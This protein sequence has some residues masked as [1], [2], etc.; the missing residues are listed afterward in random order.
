MKG[1]SHPAAKSV[2]TIRSELNLSAPSVQT[3]KFLRAILGPESRDGQNSAGKPIRQSSE[4]KKPTKSRYALKKA[5]KPRCNEDPSFPVHESPVHQ[6][7][8]LSPVDCQ[9]LATETFNATLKQ[10]S[11]A[12]KAQKTLAKPIFGSTTLPRLPLTEGVLQE[13]SPN[14]KRKVPYA[15]SKENTPCLKEPDWDVVAEC[16]FAALRF[17]Q[18]SVEA[19]T[20]DNDNNSKD[21]GIED[22]GLMLLDRSITLNLTAQ[23]YRQ[24]SDIHHRYW[25]MKIVQNYSPDNPLANFILGRPDAVNESSTFRFTASMQSQCLRLAMLLGPKCIDEALLKSLQLETVGSP[26]WVS[27]QG[28]M[29]GQHS[30]EQAGSQLRTI[31]LVLFKLYSLATKSKSETTAPIYLFDLCCV[32]LRIKFESWK[33]LNH[34]PEPAVEVWRPLHGAVKRLCATPKVTQASLS[35]ALRQLRLFRD[36]LNHAKCDDSIPSDVFEVILRFADDTDNHSK[37]LVLMEEQLPKS[38]PMPSLILNCQITTAR[39]RH[40]SKDTHAT[41]LAVN[42]IKK[43]L[44]EFTHLPETGIDRIFLHLALLRKACTEVI[45]YLENLQHGA[46]EIDL[47]TALIRLTYTTLKFLCHPFQS[48]SPSASHRSERDKNQA[49]LTTIIKTIDAVLS[50]EKCAVTQTSELEVEAYDA[51]KS[52]AAMVESL[53]SDFAECLADSTMRIAF[54]Q[55]RVRLSQVFWLRFLKAVERSKELPEQIMIL[56]LSLQGLGELPIADQKAAY[57]GLKCERLAACHLE[58][59]NHEMSKLALRRAIEFNIKEG[60]L[61]D[62][63]ELLL[64]GSSSHGWSK[65]DS[66]CRVLGRNLVAYSRGPLA[67][68]A[69]GTDD[70][71]YDDT[72]LPALHRAVLLEKQ[73]YAVI[74]NDMGDRQ[75]NFCAAQAKFVLDLLHEPRYQVYRLRFVNILLNFGLRQKL[76]TARLPLNPTD[77]QMVLAKDTKSND[78]TFLR[79]CEPALHLLLCLQFGFLIGQVNKQGLEDTT[80]RLC[81]IAQQCR[82]LEEVRG[83]LDDPAMYI[84]PLLL[85]VDYAEMFGCFR[86]ALRALEAL[87]HLMTLGVDAPGLSKT[88]LLLRSGRLFCSLQD[89][90]SAEKAFAK[91][92]KTLC[93]EAIDP[94]LEIEFALAYSDFHLKTESLDHCFE[95]LRHAEGLWEGQNRANGPMSTRIKLREQSTLCRAAHLASQL[96]YRQGKLLDAI[97]FARQAAKIIATVWASIEDFWNSSSSS[98]QEISANS[99]VHSLTAD[100]SKL[101]LSFHK[102]PQLPTTAVVYWPQISLYCNIFSN[103]AFLTAH[104]GLYQDSAY[105]YEQALKVAKKTMQSAVGAVI[106]S[107]LT[108]LHARAGQLEKAQKGLLELSPILSE[109]NLG[110]MQALVC[111]NQGEA[112]LHLGNRSAASRCLSEATKRLQLQNARLTQ[113]KVNQSWVLK[114]TKT[115]AEPSG[116]KATVKQHKKVSSRVDQS[117]GIAPAPTTVRSMT[118]LKDVYE[119]VSAFE[120]KLRP[121]DNRAAITTVLDSLV[122]S[123]DDVDNSR[124]SMREALNLVQSALK[125]FSE[126]AE[127]NVLAET[128]MAL[129]VR[130]QSVRSS[131]RVSFVQNL[132]SL[133]G[134]DGEAVQSNKRSKRKQSEKDTVR[135]GK[136]LLLEAY[137]ILRR[138]KSSLPSRIS[139]DIIHTSHK[140]L[141]QISLISTALGDPFTTSSL[142]LVLDA[143][144]PKEVARRRERVI[145]L[146]EVATAK[147]ASWPNVRHPNDLCT[148]INSESV[149]TYDMS[150]LPDSWSIVSIG[151]SE[152]RTELS[153]SRIMRERSPFVVRIPLSRPDP[154]EGGSEELDFDSA[155]A[156]IQTLISS[157][158][159]TAHDP[160][161]SSVNKAVRRAWYADRQA[162]DHQIANLL[163][164]IENVWFGGF[165]GLLSASVPDEIQLLKF[166]QCLSLALDRH[167]PS[168]Q[169]ASKLANQRI[170]LHSHVLELFVALGHPSEVELDDAIMDLLYFVVDILQFNGERNAYDEIDF[171]AMLVEVLDA[172]HS[173]HD[174]KSLETKKQASHMILVLD[175]E[176]QVFPW[177]SLS[178]LRGRGVSRMPSLGAI[179][180]RLNTIQEQS[181]Q[182]DSYIIR[183]TEGAYILNPS[184]DL[185]STQETFG[186]LFQDQLGT[187]NAIVNQPPAE[188]DFETMLH[189]KSLMLYFGHGGGAQYIRGR[190]IRKMDKCAVTLLMGCSSAKMTECG[191]YEPYGMPWN[192]LNAGSPAVVGTLW[193]VTDRDI[194][195]FAEELMAD[196]G[197]IDTRAGIDTKTAKKSGK[198]KAEKENRATR[199][200]CDQGKCGPASLDQAVAQARDAC[201]LKYLNGAAPVM[202]GIP[203]VLE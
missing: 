116:R 52:S 139:S 152:D 155:K 55:Q 93:S 21:A 175:K 67:H 109:S 94:Q 111:V 15:T 182:N 17:L 7:P 168:R 114:A 115:T 34:Q 138:V 69:S 169:K 177:E 80:Q 154:S 50:T 64:T 125:L 58:L 202:Y 134:T 78:N 151:L 140:I 43:A 12:A 172:L 77:I 165:R 68:S 192:Y 200:T 54:I 26:A 95:W 83:V 149:S 24:L 62:V 86:V 101:D 74:E 143:L 130:Y 41:L 167:L 178:C 25:G 180:E 2:D 193:D 186:Q 66:G 107:N 13:R 35:S 60:I 112:H 173:Y 188:T 4:A 36:L 174:E 128:A 162:L 195:R 61:G 102:S 82:T 76:S 113:P 96:A 19:R 59:H 99:D 124:K 137:D 150:L 38:G 81:E 3:L 32:A 126:D 9:K 87:Q 157:A 194:D 72:T 100:F 42:R 16:C 121:L 14:R 63:V 187:F 176:L 92:E 123:G 158:N 122:G 190:T 104:C 18:G 131:G 161:G 39:L 11:V 105:F 88:N 85:S 185:L 191:V 84:S 108:L 29:R 196:W 171:D 103:V 203:V 27:V 144:T 181:A 30:L 148:A 48:T 5:T 28:L 8:R 110:V 91:V 183:K 90:T 56:D 127:H 164:N 184:S 201:L 179:W 23:V 153:V 129:P 71:F 136:E 160:R 159:T 170:E 22:A 142:E 70:M 75:F 46:R 47:Q 37:L 6:L 98:Q 132:V 1:A 119:K 163:D 199:R 106:L 197:L 65:P 120:A 147:R 51:L 31:S 73:I 57:F 53:P 166:G 145:K 10:L 33:H 89:A 97:T 79:S 135:N 141:A 117:A 20:I 156:E 45:A 118:D 189:D 49:F 133:T 146:G 44:V 198:A 40:V